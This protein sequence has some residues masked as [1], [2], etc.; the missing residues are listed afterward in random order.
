MKTWTLRSQ[1]RRSDD[2][3]LRVE[4]KGGTAK[5]RPMQVHELKSAWA[6]R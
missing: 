6:A 1:A 4:A 5:I 3:S 2:L